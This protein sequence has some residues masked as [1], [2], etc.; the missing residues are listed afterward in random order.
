MEKAKKIYKSF[1]LILFI[2]ITIWSLFVRV[3]ADSNGTNTDG[4]WTNSHVTENLVE[5]KNGTLTEQGWNIT[6]EVKDAA[7]STDGDSNL[8]SFED[9]YGIQ[10]RKGAAAY[11]IGAKDYTK[12]VWVRITLSDA[13]IE[14][15]KKGDLKVNALK[16]KLLRINPQLNKIRLIIIVQY[17]YFLRKKMVLI[18]LMLVTSTIR[19][20]SAKMAMY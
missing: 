16:R 3:H 5:L 1:L 15:A 8:K 20:K 7:T 12:G 4:K 19:Q 6:D 14:K 9:S 17:K 13:D 18:T 11:D 2:F 10:A